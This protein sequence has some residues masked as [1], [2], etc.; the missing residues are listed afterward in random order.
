MR[1]ILFIKDKSAAVCDATG[2]KQD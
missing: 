2:V 1:Q